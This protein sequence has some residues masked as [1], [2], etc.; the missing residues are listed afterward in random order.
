M[1]KIGIDPGHGGID[2]GA[3]GFFLKEKDVNLAI[4]LKLRE[5]LER[6]GFPTVLSREQDQELVSRGSHHGKTWSGQELKARADKFNQARVELAVSIH[7]NSHTNRLASYL[8]SFVL[9]MGYQAERAAR[10]L[11]KELLVVTGFPD[12]GIRSSNF[13]ILRE[14]RMP[15]VLVEIGFI[16]HPPTEEWLSR[17]ENLQKVAGALGKGIASYFDQPLTREISVFLDEKKLDFTPAPFFA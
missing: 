5:V 8:A 13:Q 12:G 7:I 4:A 3:V 2:P 1:R 16:S 10:L 6:S 15:A 14:T 9:K 11:Q 17:E